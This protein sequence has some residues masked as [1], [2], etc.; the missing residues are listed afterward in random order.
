LALVNTVE[1]D[2][3]QDTFQIDLYDGNTGT[4]VATI[5]HLVLNALQW[6]QIGTILSTYAP[7]TTSGYAHITRVAGNNPFIAYAVIND[8]SRAGQRSGDGAFIAS[9]Q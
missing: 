8:G 3:G 7:G 9:S 1:T 2:P 5:P 4:K 6:T